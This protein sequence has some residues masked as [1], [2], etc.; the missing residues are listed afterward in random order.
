MTS[1]SHVRFLSY[2]LGSLIGAILSLALT[3]RSY[4]GFASGTGIPPD[5]YAGQIIVIFKPDVP[6]EKALSILDSYGFSDP[7]TTEFR[8]V[9][10]QQIR[11]EYL[12]HV[13]NGHEIHW[14]TALKNLPSVEDTGW[15]AIEYAAVRVDSDVYIPRPPPVQHRRPPPLGKIGPLSE[16]QQAVSTI[17]R[18]LEHLY[19]PKGM[20][21]WLVQNRNSLRLSISRLRNEVVATAGFWEYIELDVIV[22]PDNDKLTIYL[23]VDAFYAPGLGTEPPVSRGGYQDM[24]KTYP[25]ELEVYANKLVTTLAKVV[26]EGLR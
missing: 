13:P 19:A 1:L 7:V 22:V 23:I 15:D 6:N 21:G 9:E 20:V 12:I 26:E 2:S 25:H 4:A 18:H 8:K 10:T 5:H 17:S 3:G 16:R 24:Q 11:T 14:I